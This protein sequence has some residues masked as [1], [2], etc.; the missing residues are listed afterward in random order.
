ML[1]TTTCQTALVKGESLLSAEEIETGTVTDSIVDWYHEKFPELTS[2]TLLKIV[3]NHFIDALEFPPLIN[4][5]AYHQLDEIFGKQEELGICEDCG[6]PCYCECGPDKPC[7]CGKS[8]TC[9]Q[10]SREDLEQFFPT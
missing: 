9:G 2:D 10:E 8:C 3:I 1:P 5:A 4:G 7:E 6:K